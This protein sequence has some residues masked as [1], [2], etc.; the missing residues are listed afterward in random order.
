MTAEYAWQL[1]E[2]VRVVL[3]GDYT[4]RFP[5]RAAV[6]EFLVEFIKGQ[7]PLERVR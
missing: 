1:R 3:W 5:D 2:A 4:E 7:Q 6:D